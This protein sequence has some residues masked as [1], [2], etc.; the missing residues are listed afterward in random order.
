MEELQKELDDMIQ[1]QK[2]LFESASK[3]T[4]FIDRKIYLDYAKLAQERINLLVEL[5]DL[6]D[7][8]N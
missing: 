8:K 2:N 7:I 5:I 4:N 6:K 3:T 1:Q